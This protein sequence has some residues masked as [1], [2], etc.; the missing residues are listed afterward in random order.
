MEDKNKRSE[1]KEKELEKVSG[2]FFYEDTIDAGLKTHLTN[3]KE[4]PKGQITG[5]PRG[6][7]PSDQAL[8]I[9][10]E[11]NGALAPNE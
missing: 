1:V 11:A 2:G 7:M 6:Q 10:D 9:F 8:D 3:G 4:N 5:I